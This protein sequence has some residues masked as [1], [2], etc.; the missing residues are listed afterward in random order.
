MKRY[1]RKRLQTK[2]RA[3][4]RIA[5]RWL[6]LVVLLLAGLAVGYWL[7]MRSVSKSSLQ[8]KKQYEQYYFADSKYKGV[9]SRF[10]R[11]ESGNERVLLEYPVTGQEAIDR[12]TASAIDQADAA[13]RQ[14]V[15][16]G[17]Q[18]PYLMTETA[19]FQV[20]HH[21]KAYISIVITT[22]QDTLGAHPSFM[23]YFWTFD[24][25]TGNI[26]TLRE[27]AGG[28]DRAVQAVL[29]QAKKSITELL[30]QQSK[31]P[32]ALG[33]FMSESVLRNF[34]IADRQTIAWP[35]GQG[36]ILPS[37]YGDV[38]ARVSVADIAAHI[39]NPL[40]KSLLSVPE[41]PKPKPQSPSSSTPQYIRPS[42]SADC[43]TTKCVALTFDDGPGVHTNRLLD[44]LDGQG[45]KATF[46]VLGSQVQ[47]HP[48][49]LRRMQMSGHQIGNHSWGH[50]D[51]THIDSAQV[52]R[53]MIN[54]NTV[55]QQATGHVPTIARPPYGAVNNEVLAQ[56]AQA[57]LSSILWSVD[58]R[59]WADR[60][61]QIICHR[62]VAGARAGAIILMHDIHATSVDAVP[63]II[64]GLAKQGYSLVT[65]RQLLG[66]TVPGA[67]YTSG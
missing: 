18:F 59:D 9:K 7:V 4:P 36:A 57:G 47:K 54:T 61:N 31:P 21:D 40:A 65:I 20:T 51:L 30:Q 33:D 23:T 14:S 5:W 48:G 16:H 46:F 49:S 62:A 44:M 41:P 37:A 55:I 3:H 39:Q 32:L 8:V 19:S 2:L 10:V 6:L 27:L 67:I 52:Q 64:D 58:T 56:L 66:A 43:A 28:S 38:T 22:R 12:V 17:S 15:A 50:P 60:D 11:R 63:C 35:F 29:D 26:V 34:V 25:T 1:S 53:E 24:K 42:T 13:F 45:V